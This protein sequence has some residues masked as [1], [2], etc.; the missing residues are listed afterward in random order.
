MWRYRGGRDGHETL[1]QFMSFLGRNRDE[2]L[3]G[4]E[5]RE[6]EGGRERRDKG[7]VYA[8]VVAF[9]VPSALAL[10]SAGLENVAQHFQVCIFNLNLVRDD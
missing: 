7:K 5:M 2:K 8:G 10:E 9:C 1:Q 6:E 4:G 3:E